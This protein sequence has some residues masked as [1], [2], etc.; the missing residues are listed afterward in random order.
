MA[1][2]TK[3]LGMPR[4]GNV[5]KGISLH[6]RR[7]ALTR[8]KARCLR[9]A[10]G[11][12][13]C[14]VEELADE[15]GKHDVP[16]LTKSPPTTRLTDKE[17]RQRIWAIVKQRAPQAKTHEQVIDWIRKTTGLALH[18]DAYVDILARLEDQ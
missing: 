10:L 5:T 15:S 18:A 8:A 1:G 6:F 4:P 7:V 13:E 11:I 2:A 9:D 17:L 12:S 3:N 16:D 14:S